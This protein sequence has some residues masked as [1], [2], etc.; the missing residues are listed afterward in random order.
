[1]RIYYAH[2]VEIYHTPREFKEIEIIK[3]HYPQA[4]IVNP[5]YF[6][7][8]PGALHSNID[9]FYSLVD[10]CD[11]LIY[12]DLGGFVTAGVALEVKRALEQGKPVYR[13][14]WRTGELT[15]IRELRNVLSLEETQSIIDAMI[16]LALD[17]VEIASIINNALSKHQGKVALLNIISS[18]TNSPEYQK[19]ERIKESSNINILSRFYHWWQEPGNASHIVDTGKLKDMISAKLSELGE[20]SMRSYILKTLKLS[21]TRYDYYTYLLKNRAPKP[22][23]VRVLK[24]L[25]DDFK[26]PY[27][28]L[29][30]HNAFTNIK[31]PID[32]DKPGLFMLASHILNEGHM[33]TETKSIEYY[34]KD[35]VL[36]YYLKQRVE[37]LGGSFS[38]P[39]EAHK[40]F[41][42]YIDPLTGRLLNAIG[43]PYGP[44]AQN[45]PFVSFKR[46]DNSTWKYHFQAT[47]TEE[48]AITLRVMQ[49]KRIG[50]KISL[51]RAIDITDLL[52]KNFVS[53]LDYGAHSIGKTISDEKIYRTIISNP[54]TLL[55][56]EFEELTR[57]H[58]RQIPI[59]AWRPPYPYRIQKSKDDRIT[60]HW[61]LE[62]IKTHL[63]DLIYNYYGMLPGT[64]KSIAFEKRYQFYL[65]HR[66]QKLTENEIEELHQ[67]E[68]QYPWEIPK[69][70]I[71]Q[72]IKELFK[73]NGAPAGI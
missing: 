3:R 66:G 18:I 38:G 27:V 10:S 72:K 63:V 36:H 40:A 37:E 23:E 51:T 4:E 70:W 55:Q 19:K 64:W 13:L 14:D 53:S 73:S 11:I 57:R 17:D 67:I 43:I 8:K 50:M 49:D 25:C 28:A 65:E 60:I 21:K 33:R 20:K 2:P 5:A 15:Q 62:I 48:G 24:R 6:Q 46:M 44:R 39:F 30:Q 1:M 58:S 35:P 47:L 12:S 34:N 9:F 71:N 41:A 7:D 45:Q 68:K 26:I 29:E 56:A 61:A 32:L 69:Q 31:F 59:Y 22:I 42:S 52:P 54:P 16:Y